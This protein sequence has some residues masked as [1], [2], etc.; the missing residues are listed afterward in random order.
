MLCESLGRP[1]RST[2]AWMGHS[3]LKA[4][5]QGT[6]SASIPTSWIQ[7]RQVWGLSLR[8]NGGQAVSSCWIEIRDIHFHFQEARFSFVIRGIWDKLTLFK[9]AKEACLIVQLMQN[10]S[11]RVCV[12]GDYGWFKTTWYAR[13]ESNLNKLEVG[14]SHCVER[15]E[16]WV[17]FWQKTKKKAFIFKTRSRN[18]AAISVADKYFHYFPP[19]SSFL[20]R[21]SSYYKTL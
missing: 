15:A 10:D 8:E 17:S 16:S 12:L 13:M 4:D 7:K 5:G 9:R 2:S 1:I 20:F 18:P 19:P 3:W 21:L 11:H 6:P 14:V